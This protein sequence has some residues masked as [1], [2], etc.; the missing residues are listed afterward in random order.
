MVAFDGA[1]NEAV[2]TAL[3]SALTAPAQGGLHLF[4]IRVKGENGDWGPVFKRTIATEAAP[5][6]IKITLA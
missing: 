4:N 2:E 6:E 1:F 3:Q 5:R